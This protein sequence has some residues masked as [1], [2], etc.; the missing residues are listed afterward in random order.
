MG[1][2]GGFDFVLCA[3][4]LCITRGGAAAAGARLPATHYNFLFQCARLIFLASTHGAGG[5]RLASAD[6]FYR[7]TSEEVV[8]GPPVKH[9]RRHGAGN[10]AEQHLHT[11]PKQLR[12]AKVFRSRR[13]LLLKKTALLHP[14]AGFVHAL[15]VKCVIFKGSSSRSSDI[16]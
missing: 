7:S 6:V 4:L 15:E 8:S 14:T 11:Q 1:D 10:S 16:K 5:A 2:A 13:R 9:T 3:L 12:R